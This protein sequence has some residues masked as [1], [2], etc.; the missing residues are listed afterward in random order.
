MKGCQV[1]DLGKKLSPLLAT[2][3]SSLSGLTFASPRRVQVTR[4]SGFPRQAQVKEASS[5]VS[6]DRGSGFACRTGPTEGEEGSRD[7]G[8]RQ[9]LTREQPLKSSTLKGPSIGPQS[10]TPL[11]SPGPA[12]APPLLHFGTEPTQPNSAYIL[13]PPH[14]FPQRVGATPLSS[15]GFISAGL[16]LARPTAPPQLTLHVQRGAAVGATHSVADLARHWCG[17]E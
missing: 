7:R 12:L 6:T 16:T 4:G 1:Q 15:P 14:L 10:T 2:T 17:Q 11:T 9:L 5:P 13:C 8:G 3:T